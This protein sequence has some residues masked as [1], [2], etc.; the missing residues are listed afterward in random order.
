[1]SPSMKR[2]SVIGCR[3][4]AVTELI[5]MGVNGELVNTT[6]KALA[7]VTLHL[8][9]NLSLRET[10]GQMGQQK[11]KEQFTWERIVQNQMQVYQSLR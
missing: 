5:D 4:P 9:E 7:A 6:L 10:M 11:V 2:V 8:L 3:I 1:M